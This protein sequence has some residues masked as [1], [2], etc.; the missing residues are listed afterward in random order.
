M[1]INADLRDGRAAMTAAEYR[2]TAR[3]SFRLIGLNDIR[4]GSRI[5]EWPDKQSLDPCE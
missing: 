4:N 1:A 5:S 3:G 2:F